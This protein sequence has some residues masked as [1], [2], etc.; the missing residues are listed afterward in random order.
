MQI[1]VG[2]LVDNS[3]F[4]YNGT[5]YKIA[6]SNWT[7]MYCGEHLG[8][9]GTEETPLEVISCNPFLGGQFQ[10]KIKQ[11]ITLETLVSID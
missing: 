6:G 9:Q 4:T 11:F 5:K 1:A 8:T 7:T 3:I 10:S 2:L